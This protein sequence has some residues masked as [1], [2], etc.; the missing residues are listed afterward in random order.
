MQS[1]NSGLAFISLAMAF[2]MALGCVTIM[3]A[4][5]ADMEDYDKDLG[6]FW[7]YT[8]QFIFDGS[9]AQTISWDFGDGSEPSTE[10]NPRHEFP[11]KGVYIV[12]Q[13]TSNTEGETV[14]HYRLEIKGFPYITLVYN[15]GSEDGTIQQDAYNVPATEPSAPVK[16]G[17]A[18][19]GWYTDN[20]CTEPYDWSKGVT[21]PITLYAGWETSGQDDE[22]DGDGED[23][24]ILYAT[25]ACVIVAV[26]LLVA[27]V[28]TGSAFIAVPA[29]VLAIVSVFL[30]L[31]HGGVI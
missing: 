2:I 22:G 31:I 27:A 15:N 3:D 16:D 23:N 18:F 5:D 25:I 28:M 13:T 8:V 7:S 12:T 29:A 1:E 9:D 26:I 11:A 20:G 21:E 17:S 10:F 6:S 30:G 19:R 14:E 24:V 4:S